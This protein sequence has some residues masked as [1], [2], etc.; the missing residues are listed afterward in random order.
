MSSNFSFFRGKWDVLANLGESAENN[1]YHDPHTTIMKLRLFG[2]TLTKFILA[3]EN[4]RETYDTR[5][6]DRINTLRREG[7]I[8]TEL[9]D[10][11]ETICRKGNR[12]S[13][14]AEYG[15]TEEAKVL[16]IIAFRLSVWF[17]EVYGEWDFQ[18]PE[19]IEPTER[20]MVDVEKL[21]KE[22]DEKRKLEEQLKQAREKAEQ[23]TGQEKK[24]RRKKSKLFVQRHQLTEAETRI[25]ID[26]KL[27]SAGWD[28][29]TEK[30]NYHKN[31]TLPE[32]N[33][34]MAIAEWND[35]N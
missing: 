5:Q 4:I 35:W 3:S 18:A 27:S 13:H 8:E 31:G 20:E 32:K 23:E 10:M 30:L 24:E 33:R 7:I 12:A 17:M 14:E 25:I 28:V 22:Y 29:D 15:N 16:L 21:I 6:V 2:E 34:N 19:Y 26:E 11:F 1:V 9:I